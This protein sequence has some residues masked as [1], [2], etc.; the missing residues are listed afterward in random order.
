MSWR[1]AIALGGLAFLLHFAVLDRGLLLDDW[2]ILPRV[3]QHG[4]PEP[5]PVTGDGS[6]I[7]LGS[8]YL[9][10]PVP[11]PYMSRPLLWWT[12][13][14]ISDPA[15]PI[16]IRTL[17][18]LS[19]V[20]HVASTILLAR[21]LGAWV[22][23]PAA[24]MGATLFA[25]SPG[26][27]Q[28]ISWIAAGGDVL[29]LPLVLLGAIA[30]TRV[31]SD[32]R[33]SVWTYI[34]VIIMSAAAVLMKENVSALL[35]TLLAVTAFSSTKGAR[36]QNV[37]YASLA[38]MFA[39]GIAAQIGGSDAGI[40]VV[41]NLRWATVFNI[42]Y[43]VAQLF[44]QC[45]VPINLV[46]PPSGID[47]PYVL[48]LRWIGASLVGLLLVLGFV[49]GSRDRRWGIVTCLILF[50]VAL[51][52]V[53]AVVVVEAQT[54]RTNFLSRLVYAPWCGVIVALTLAFDAISS[55]SARWVARV[56]FVNLILASFV[57]LIHVR[58]NERFTDA[59]VERRVA[60]LAST[61][62][63]TT[64]I[65]VDPHV[66][67]AGAPAL[68][69][70]VEEAMSGNFASPRRHVVWTP[71]IESLGRAK[72]LTAALGPIK[73]FDFTAD[74]LGFAPAVMDVRTDRVAVPSAGRQP[75]T[76]LLALDPARPVAPQGILGI[77]LYGRSLGSALVTT[78]FSG[79]RAF[80]V[81]VPV[82]K[83]A[84]E[85][86]VEAPQDLEWPL[87]ASLD[88]VRVEGLALGSEWEWVQS[89]P[90]PP[91]KIADMGDASRP[92]R[93]VATV[94]GGTASLTTLWR[95]YVRQGDQIAWAT[96]VREVPCPPGMSTSPTRDVVIS[97]GIDEPIGFAGS[98][99]EMSWKSAIAALTGL[100]SGGI[101]RSMQQFEVKVI[102]RGIGVVPNPSPWAIG[103]IRLK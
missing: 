87:M 26:G 59:C 13:Q 6:A 12:W 94:P 66:F 25:L 40:A 93:L 33:H 22:S 52:P 7:A 84:E 75:V 32:G 57:A 89:S 64:S 65:V 79:G 44:L 1:F 43:N 9:G 45:L 99:T 16:P 28:A 91:L 69:F 8:R 70:G 97:P 17:H 2:W 60:A 77:R 103:H 72:G 46:L 61:T 73:V 74:P 63:E 83:Y 24:A 100:E 11:P 101:T 48:T 42:P 4:A 58:S 55:L 98:S 18:G 80:S 29:S 85:H 56:V 47:P 86:I 62:P 50:L 53:C 30:L 21:L 15:A 49:A 31:N 102:P 34:W 19:L 10:D 96:A 54:I 88:R 76:D 95:F 71:D 67:I 51:V 92:P 23:S 3:V 14:W 78:W 81:A 37:L 68:G 36:L 39:V 90:A 35:P 38:I 5:W 41:Q 27:A 82:I 20:A